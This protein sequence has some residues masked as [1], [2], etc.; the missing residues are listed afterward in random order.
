MPQIVFV[1]TALGRSV[2]GRVGPSVRLG[3]AITQVPA[4]ALGLLIVLY[5]LWGQSHEKFP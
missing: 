4:I 1:N 3:R 2:F 5:N